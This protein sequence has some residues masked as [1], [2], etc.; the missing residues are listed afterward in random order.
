MCYENLD[1]IYSE[2][3]QIQMGSHCKKALIAENVRDS[4]HSWCKRV[5]ERSKHNTVNSIT[6][7]STCSLG[8]TIDEGDEIITVASATISPCSSTGSLNNMLDDTMANDLPDAPIIGS[9][10][11]SKH[12]LSFRV[13][14]YASYGFNY[15]N[16]IQDNVDDEEGKV[17]T[18]F[19]LLRKT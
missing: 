9:S 6:T 11:R 15:E 10:D 4:L 14:E 12:E 5:K 19:D 13:S 8:S 18:L 3:S 1:P 17:E 7:R 16:E 2:L